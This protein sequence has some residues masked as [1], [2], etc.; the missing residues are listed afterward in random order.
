M[1]TVVLNGTSS[2]G[3]TTLAR[4]LQ[5]AWPGPLQVSGLD[6]FLG[7]QGRQMFAVPGAAPS[8]GFTW[9]RCTVEGVD[10]WAVVPGPR[11][12]AL[13]RAAHAFWAACADEGLDQ[14]VDHVLLTRAAADDLA[15]RLAGRDVLWVGVHC[16][17]AEVDRRERERGDRLVGQGRGIA[18]T[19]HDHRAY[20]VEVDTSLLSP[21]QAAAVVLDALAQR[22]ASR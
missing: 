8:D 19:V 11:G 13:L 21:Q 1:A 16:P 5:D 9:Q 7:S 10:A 17:L 18:A 6:T 12:A 2:A 3:K 22:Q 20:D 15:I 4:A 14:V